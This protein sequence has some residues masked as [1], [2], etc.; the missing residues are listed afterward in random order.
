[1]VRQSGAYVPP[2]RRG[3]RGNV[4]PFSYLVR[5]RRLKAK[6]EIGLADLLGNDT[7]IRS[8]DDSVSIEK[9]ILRHMNITKYQAIFSEINADIEKFNTLLAEEFKIPHLDGSNS[10]SV[11]FIANIPWDSL[12]EWT[13]GVYPGVYLLCG[14]KESDTNLLGAYIGKA[15]LG[16]GIGNRI[17]FHLRQYGEIG[18][19]KMKN[20]SGEAF[21]IEVIVAVA[22][23]DV[24]A[25]A[26][27]P[28]LEEF[29]ISG[30]RERVH[31]L[32]SVG[33]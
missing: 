19:Y 9:S 18:D 15:S 25:K 22:L 8:R 1:M 27:A 26:L 16:A 33:N 31:L 5:R 32:N 3:L 7:R 2:Q 20:S 13:F 11:H 14:Y 29:L 12:P 28:A 24:R 21:I 30:V 4:V 10:D 6:A 17:W 23:R